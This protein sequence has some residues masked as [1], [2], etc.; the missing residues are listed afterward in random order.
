MIDRETGKPWPARFSPQRAMVSLARAARRTLR[1]GHRFGP[2]AVR[3]LLSGYARGVAA[4]WP[5]RR[6]ELRKALFRRL[7]LE[8]GGRR[9]RAKRTLPNG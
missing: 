7:R 8:L 2:A 4:A 1:D 6:G 5:V 3:R 9:G